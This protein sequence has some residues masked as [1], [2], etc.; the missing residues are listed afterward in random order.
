MEAHGADAASDLSDPF[1]ANRSEVPFTA[2]EKKGAK[3]VRQYVMGDSLGEG[4]QGKVR[5]AL[6]SE[7]LRRVAIKIINLRQ[8]RKVRHAEPALEREDSEEAKL[9]PLPK[10][11]AHVSAYRAW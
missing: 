1:E 8:L 5:E 10:S 2:K 9:A 4:S 7:T 3:M 11:S 6:N